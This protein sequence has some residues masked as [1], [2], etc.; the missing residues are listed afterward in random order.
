M[1]SRTTASLAFRIAGSRSRRKCT[2]SF[3]LPS[4][5][6]GIGSAGAPARSVADSSSYPGAARATCGRPSTTIHGMAFSN[7]ATGHVQVVGYRRCRHVIATLNPRCNFIQESERHPVHAL[8]CRVESLDHDVPCGD[9]DNPDAVSPTR[10]L[11][12]LALHSHK[13]RAEVHHDG[14]YP[15]GDDFRSLASGGRRARR[16][17][18]VAA[19]TQS[20]LLAR[21]DTRPALALDGPPL[22]AVLCP[23]D[24]GGHRPRE[25]MAT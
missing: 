7:A 24:T 18:V 9:R 6:V 23:P 5:P 13:Q 10:R 12:V 14:A 3:G 8:T 15:P 16:V 11:N 21:S 22:A 20:A 2:T 19:S 4:Q 1:A 17:P 25:P